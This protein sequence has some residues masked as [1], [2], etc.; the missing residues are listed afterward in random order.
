MKEDLIRELTSIHVDDSEKIL[1]ASRPKA[2]PSGALSPCDMTPEDVDYEMSFQKNKRILQICGMNQKSFEYFVEKYGESYE[3]LYFFKCQL[4]SDFSPLSKLKNLKAVIIWWNIR[5][6]KL[7][8]MSQ[9]ISLKQISIND[10]KKITGNLG[11]LATSKTL[12]EV[13]IYGSI[14]N[15]FV[16]ESLD[17]FKN[18]ASLKELKLRN[19][20]LKNRSIDFLKDT[21]NLTEFNFDSGMLTTEQIAYICARYPHIKGTALCAYNKID[22]ILS[23]VRICGYRKPGIN[24]PE[25]QKR[26]EKYIR[27]FDA[28]VEKYKTEE[29]E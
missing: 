8:D 7:W 24:L 1:C 17:P 14:F 6:D 23:D 9:N 19:I 22:A 29:L 16:I 15:N 20:T 18:I 2:N 13:S 3:A 4:I 28:L 5:S 11:G 10:C 12:E 26:L 27:E 21:P 25:G